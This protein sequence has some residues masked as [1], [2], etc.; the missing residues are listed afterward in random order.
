[1]GVAR[2]AAPAVTGRLV[3]Q[4]EAKRQNAGEDTL[5]KRLA[6]AQEL[7]VGC[8]V[9]KVDSNCSV[10]AGRVGCVSHGVTFK[11]SG[12]CRVEHNLGV[13]QII[14]RTWR[15]AETRYH[16][17]RGNVEKSVSP[18]DLLPSERGSS[19]KG[20]SLLHV[21]ARPNG[22]ASARRTARGSGLPIGVQSLSL[23]VREQRPL[24]HHPIDRAG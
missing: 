23:G 2:Q 9:L 21:D 22:R 3:F 19:L 4:L 14:S 24:S 15:R 6:I 5:N 12:L 20:G 10:F 16:V 18:E 13:T 11:S 7:N 17:I 8:L 1:M